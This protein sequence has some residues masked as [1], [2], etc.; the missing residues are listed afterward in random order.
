M[1]QT[2][3]QAEQSA[4]VVPNG[5]DTDDSL[6]YERGHKD[7]FENGANWQKEQGTIQWFEIAKDGLPKKISAITEIGEYTKTVLV[8]DGAMLHITQYVYLN[9]R[10]IGW[11][12]GPSLLL[13]PT[14]WA[15]INLP[16][17][18]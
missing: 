16:K 4:L 3:E 1:K 10:P 18:E 13:E 9:G 2:I 7:G 14:H 6:A 11:F 17:P 5:L 8:T 15:Y 12:G